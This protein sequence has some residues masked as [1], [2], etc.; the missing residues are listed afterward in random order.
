MTVTSDPLA[1]P[2][3]QNALPSSVVAPRTLFPLKATGSA[4]VVLIS[5]VEL[6]R[7]TARFTVA[8]LVLAMEATP[9]GAPYPAMT[10]NTRRK[11]CAQG[12]GLR[13][14]GTGSVA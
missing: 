7:P 1:V 12:I 5:P 10:T 4:V 2:D 6:M 14:M 9:G 8:E 13:R 3:T 11:S